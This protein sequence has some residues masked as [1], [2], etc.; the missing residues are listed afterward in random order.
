MGPWSWPQDTGARVI[1]FQAEPSACPSADPVTETKEVHP[2]QQ[3]KNLEGAV[4]APHTGGAK[5][6]T[7]ERGKEGQKLGAPPREPHSRLHPHETLALPILGF[8][9]SP[10]IPI[11]NSTFLP[12]LLANI[13]PQPQRPV[14]VT[15]AVGPGKALFQYP[16]PGNTPSRNAHPC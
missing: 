7:S 15:L 14:L 9:V 6:R 10:W 13:R 1:P 16:V 5:H 4:S 12:E 11:T 3:L 8:I 2:C